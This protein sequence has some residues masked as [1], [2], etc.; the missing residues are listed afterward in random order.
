[1]RLP[2]N[3]HKV[4]HFEFDRPKLSLF[5]FFFGSKMI[6]EG[7]ISWKK[8]ADP[9]QFH[10]GSKI[11]VCQIQSGWFFEIFVAFSEY[12]NLANFEEYLIKTQLPKNTHSEIISPCGKQSL[13]EPCKFYMRLEIA[14]NTMVAFEIFCLLTNMSLRSVGV[15]HCSLVIQGSG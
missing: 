11:I 8:H 12:M 5:D 6:S 13:K 1:M 10:I 4:T 9:L 7:L 15:E 3:F 14:S 2:Q